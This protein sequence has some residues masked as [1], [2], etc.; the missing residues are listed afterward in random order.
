MQN[1]PAAVENQCIISGATRLLDKVIKMAD[2]GY[3]AATM[4]VLA[5]VFR[6]DLAGNL[7]E[8]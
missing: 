1:D 8:S 7:R 3:S 2:R 6:L 4:R 5:K